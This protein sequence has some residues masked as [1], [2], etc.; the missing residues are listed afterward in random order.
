MKPRRPYLNTLKGIINTE[1]N[2]IRSN[3]RDMVSQQ[4]A[5]EFSRGSDPNILLEV[6]GDRAIH[7]HPN[8]FH[9][10]RMVIDSPEI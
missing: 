9:R 5:A 7:G 6:I 8:G 3:L 2:P 1:H 4:R 10:S